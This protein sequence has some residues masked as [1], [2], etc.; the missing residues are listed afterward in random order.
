[1][2]NICDIIPWEVV[3]NYTKRRNLE[4][5]RHRSCPASGTGRSDTASGTD[6]FSISRHPGTFPARGKVSALPGRA[7]PW[8]TWG[9]HLG[10]QIL[11]WLVCTGEC[12]DYRS[13]TASGTDRSVT[14]SGTGPLSCLH[15]QTGDKSKHQTSLHLPCK[16]RT[17]L[18]RVLWSLKLRRELHS[19]VCWQRLTESKEEQ[20]PTRDNSNN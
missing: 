14:A 5:H 9:N 8:S 3:L 4:E 13:Y 7:L 20:A 15:L 10:F 12:V 1:M 11:Q 18:Q 16:R 6:H 17:C 19:Q 2:L